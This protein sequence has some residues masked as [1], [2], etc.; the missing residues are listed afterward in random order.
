MQ[1]LS[2][3]RS[4][5]NKFFRNPEACLSEEFRDLRETVIAWATALVLLPDV[6]I[7]YQFLQFQKKIDLWYAKGRE[8]HNTLQPS[9][10]PVLHIVPDIETEY[11]EKSVK[12]DSG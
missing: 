6:N 7:D 4:S 12:T 10:H 5:T 3:Y 2:A 11:R 8:Y 9:Q 1:Q